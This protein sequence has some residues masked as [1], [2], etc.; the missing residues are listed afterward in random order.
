MCVCWASWRIFN[1]FLD[2]G[3]LDV[4]VNIRLLSV[5]VSI[6]T[7]EERESP[8]RRNRKQA[9][10]G[11]LLNNLYSRSSVCLKFFIHLSPKGRKEGE[12]VNVEITLVVISSTVLGGRRFYFMEGNRQ[13]LESPRERERAPRKS[14]LMVDT[15]LSRRLQDDVDPLIPHVVFFSGAALTRV[16]ERNFSLMT[17]S[18]ST[19][20]HPP[21]F[22]RFD[23]TLW[24]ALTET[25][26]EIV[27]PVHLKY[28]KTKK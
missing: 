11:R 3:G 17:T 25:D 20:L 4:T 10:W 15:H 6:Q 13:S 21:H 7:L 9:G 5:C 24:A 19:S 1:G 2:V 14:Y 22:S 12:N 23:K 16:G 26:R 28:R 18:T 8:N 27:H